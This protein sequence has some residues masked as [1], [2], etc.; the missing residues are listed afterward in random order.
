MFFLFSVE[1]Q[2]PAYRLSNQKTARKVLITVGQLSGARNA[3]MLVDKVKA[4]AVPVRETD[5]HQSDE[6]S[7]LHKVLR[8]GRIEER[9]ILPVPAEERTSTRFFNIF[10]VWFSINA[11]IL[12]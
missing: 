4:T 2:S 10:T 6:E 1:R 11:N 8:A 9:G 12:G 5:G 3:Q 7:L